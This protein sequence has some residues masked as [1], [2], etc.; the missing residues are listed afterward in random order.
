MAGI[1]P[2][3]QGDTY[4]PALFYFRDD[5]GNT[6]TLPA[7]TVLTLYIYNPKT[8]SITTGTGTWNTANLATLGQ[9]TYQWGASDTSVVGTFK[10][11]VHFVT[12]SSQVGSTDEIQWAIL[13]LFV[14]Q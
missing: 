10:L 2:M 5:Y 12:P 8:N 6:V 7:G 3:H 13:P 1:T 9:A 4:P 14:Q 11:Y